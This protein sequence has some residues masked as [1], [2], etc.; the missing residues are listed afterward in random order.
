MT[1]EER[2]QTFIRDSSTAHFASLRTDEPLDEYTRFL[3]R[4]GL[5][6]VGVFIAATGIIAIAGGGA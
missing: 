3:A 2:T 4:F 1:R 5:T 6:I